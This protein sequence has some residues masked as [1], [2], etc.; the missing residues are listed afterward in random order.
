MPTYRNLRN[1]RT[2]EVDGRHTGGF[3]S[4]PTLYERVAVHT[5]DV[6]DRTF[7]SPQGLASHARTHSED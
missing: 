1:G 2:F 3:D 6:C 5:C 4:R 7:D